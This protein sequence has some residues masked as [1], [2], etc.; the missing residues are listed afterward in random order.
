MRHTKICI[1][2]VNV[3][4]FAPPPNAVHVACEDSLN[5]QQLKKAP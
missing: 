4:V 3:I 5:Y 1:F 2:A